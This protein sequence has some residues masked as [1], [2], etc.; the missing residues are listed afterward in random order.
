MSLRW[1]IMNSLVPLTKLLGKAHAPFAHKW[2]TGAD[3]Y[4]LKPKLKPGMALLTKTRGELTNLFLPGDWTHA[5]MYLGDNLVVEAVGKGVTVTDLVSF[6]VTKDFVMARRPKFLDDEGM[7]LAAQMAESKVGLPYDWE[8]RSIPDA[9]TGDDVRQETDKAF[10]CSKLDWWGYNE[11]HKHIFGKP[12][13]FELRDTWGV[14]VV[15]PADIALSSKFE[16]IFDSR[17]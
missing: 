17:D 13:P 11:A 14:P 10:Y 12:A 9:L 3:Y 1:K 8:M 4:A 7:A 2:I 15:T 16:T 6:M 5:A